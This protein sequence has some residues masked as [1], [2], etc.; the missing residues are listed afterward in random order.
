MKIQFQQKWNRYNRE[1]N[2]AA[3]Y[4]LYSL[5]SAAE[6]ILKDV[7]RDA[8]ANIE[9]NN[10][11]TGALRDSLTIK[12][13]VKK[14]GKRKGETGGRFYALIGSDK[15]YVKLDKSGN[16][17]R[18]VR[19]AH[20]VEYGH[21]IVVSKGKSK[22]TIIGETESSFFLTKAIAGIENEIQRKFSAVAE[23]AWKKNFKD[24]VNF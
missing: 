5:K 22:G 4:V 24:V 13:K 16:I 12:S 9:S 2:Q 6:D 10:V 8:R 20:L 23:K 19:Y 21:K 11:E 14:I 18:P 17:V 7:L 3:L 15:N 1:Q